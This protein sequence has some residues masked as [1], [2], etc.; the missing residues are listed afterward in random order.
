[1]SDIDNILVI[2]D[3]KAKALDE[4][5]EENDGKYPDFNAEN[6]IKM[7]KRAF[8]IAKKRMCSENKG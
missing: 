1:M 7:N 6:I 2:S 8:L 3:D 5:L 4:Y